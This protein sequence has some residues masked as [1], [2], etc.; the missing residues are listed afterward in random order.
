MA[1]PQRFPVKFE[2]WSTEQQLAGLE[3]LCSDGLSDKATHL[4]QALAM[5]LRAAGISQ[6]PA[7]PANGQQ[8]HQERV[9]GL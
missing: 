5:Y 6:K 8:H 9:N 2:F 3:M 7:Q 4:R 1:R